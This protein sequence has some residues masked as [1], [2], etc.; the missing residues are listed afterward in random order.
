M[1][2]RREALIGL[3]VRLAEQLERAK[4]HVRQR[5]WLAVETAGVGF[6]FPLKEAGEIFSISP[7]LPVP[8]TYP[9]FL[10]VTNLRG[11]LHGVVDMALFLRLRSEVFY[12][13][14]SRMIVFNP[15]LGINCALVI[16]R[17]SGLMIEGEITKEP[18]RGDLRPSFLVDRYRDDS[19]RSWQELCLE[20][21]AV[22][23]SF[24]KIS[25]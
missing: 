15:S 11:H 20:S 19:G 1:A 8:H 4:T 10:G 25:H 2:R 24:L 9:W 12:R 17:L 23:D 22:T 18:E 7:I 13:E 14:H 3:Q 6:L 21:L 16:D 5:S